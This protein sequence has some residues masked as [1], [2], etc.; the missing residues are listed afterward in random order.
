METT[1]LSSKGQVIIPKWL[2]DAYR[3]EAGLEFVVID[4]GEGVLLKPS[5]PFAPA[6]LDDVAGSLPYDGPAR[7][8]EEMED[9]VRQA[10]QER[11]NDR[12]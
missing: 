3:W 4:T 6:N 12:R 10:I 5:R 7:T 2:R 8:I 1:K 9:G 11:W